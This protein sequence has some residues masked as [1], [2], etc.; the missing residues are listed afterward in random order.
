MWTCVP[1]FLRIWK[2]DG[3]EWL[4]HLCMQFTAASSCPDTGLAHT[5]TNSCS[6]RDVA[7]SSTHSCSDCKPMGAS[8]IATNM[9]TRVRYLLRIWKRDGCE[10]LPHLCMQCT[11]TNSCSNMWT[12]VQNLLPIWQC[13]GCKRLPNV[14]MQCTAKNSCPYQS[15]GARELLAPL[16]QG[17]VG[18]WN[19]AMRQSIGSI[20]W[21]CPMF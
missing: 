2:C 19:V 18:S 4:P 11:A 21:F 1:D 6:N 3:C 5:S 14:C 10:W 17:K 20:P 12:C 7:D 16:F 8:P 15:T 13:D 9:W